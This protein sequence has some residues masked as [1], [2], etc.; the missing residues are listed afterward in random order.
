MHPTLENTAQ[1]LHVYTDSIQRDKQRGWNVFGDA[2][3]DKESSGQ[4]YR[5]YTGD[6]ILNKPERLWR[7]E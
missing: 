3:Y 5:I 4:V 6:R 7:K 1:V 2:K